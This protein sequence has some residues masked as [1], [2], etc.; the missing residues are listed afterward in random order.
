MPDLH[1]NEW[2]EAGQIVEEAVSTDQH[3]REEVNRGV[4]SADRARRLD[5]LG[6][7]AGRFAHDFS[8]L[9]ATI[10]LNLTLV[11]KRCTD[12]TA[13]WLTSS[14]LRAAGRGAGLAQRLLAIAGK[15]T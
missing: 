2:A 3:L 14:A 5:D 10:M 4:A 1:Y 6:E 8:N 7:L 9:L 13:R 11:E 15:Q 12:P